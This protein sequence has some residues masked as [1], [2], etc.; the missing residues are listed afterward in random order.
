M[1]LSYF[2]E[3][4]FWSFEDVGFFSFMIMGARKSSSDPVWG[5]RALIVLASEN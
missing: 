4:F 2:V 1:F 5:A 3:N